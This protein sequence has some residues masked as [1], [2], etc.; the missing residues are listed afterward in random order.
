M[1]I[2]PSCKEIGVATMSFLMPLKQGSVFSRSQNIS[3]IKSDNQGTLGFSGV[4]FTERER[5]R[6]LLSEKE[7]ES[8]RE[9]ERE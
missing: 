9:T 3:H 2:I 8:R 6:E 7:R 5:N 1:D 4:S